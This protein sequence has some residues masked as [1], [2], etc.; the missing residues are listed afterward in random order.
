MLVVVAIEEQVF[1]LS[2]VNMELTSE[3]F[4]KWTIAYK[5]DK[6]QVA[7]YTKLCEGQKYEDYYLNPS[8]L[9]KTK[10]GSIEDHCSE[11]FAKENF[12]GMP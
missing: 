1:A 8:S 12:E 2:G 3:N 6:G 5:E 9:M 10:G 7:T 11:V 4:Q